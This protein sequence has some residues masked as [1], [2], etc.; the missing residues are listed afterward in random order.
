MGVFFNE[1]RGDVARTILKVVPAYARRSGGFVDT[2]PSVR[3]Y[4]YPSHALMCNV[5]GPRA[6]I[7]TISYSRYCVNVIMT[8]GG[9]NVVGPLRVDSSITITT[10][11]S[12]IM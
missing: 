4:T 2:R 5:R 9:D 7:K 11:Y 10:Y 3:W 12:T 6:R 1:T 8:D